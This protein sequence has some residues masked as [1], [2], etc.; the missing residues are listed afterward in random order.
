MVEMRMS[1]VTL[2]IVFIFRNS[3]HKWMCECGATKQKDVRTKLRR[4][5]CAKWTS[6]SLF[7]MYLHVR[8]CANETNTKKVRILTLACQ[9]HRPYTFFPFS[10][11]R[12]RPSIQTLLKVRIMNNGVRDNLEMARRCWRWT[13]GLYIKGKSSECRRPEQIFT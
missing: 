9:T 1:K 12:S 11:W 5:W 6:P 8:R 3:Y 7:V 2:I 13:N 4:I 10:L